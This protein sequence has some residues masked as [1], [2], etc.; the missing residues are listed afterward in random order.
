MVREGFR[1]IIV[2]GQHCIA[3]IRELHKDAAEQ[4]NWKRENIEVFITMQFD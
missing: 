2:D 4:H 3:V 1:A